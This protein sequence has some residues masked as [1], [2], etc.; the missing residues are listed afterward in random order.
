MQGR[1]HAGIIAAPQVLSLVEL[2]RRVQLHLDTV[3]SEAQSDT[4]L[5]LGS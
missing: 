3:S 1:T 5:E 2:T 4:L